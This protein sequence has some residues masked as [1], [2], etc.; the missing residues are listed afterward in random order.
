MSYVY[1]EFTH[2]YVFE[3]TVYKEDGADIGIYS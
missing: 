1:Y 3:I 2:E